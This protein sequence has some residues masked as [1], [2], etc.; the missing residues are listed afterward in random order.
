MAGLRCEHSYH[1][2]GAAQRESNQ[3]PKLRGAGSSP[4]AVASLR[5][6]KAP[7]D[8]CGNRGGAICTV[9]GVGLAANETP[10]RCPKRVKKVLT[11]HASPSRAS[12][13]RVSHWSAGVGDSNP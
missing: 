11:L 5:N 6:D 13:L 4:A 10:S 12:G 2:S 7:P 8:V 3:P 9:E 1:S